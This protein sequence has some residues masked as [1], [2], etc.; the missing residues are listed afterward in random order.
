MIIST[1]PLVDVWAATTK[2]GPRLPAV[3]PGQC[4]SRPASWTVVVAEG[5]RRNEENSFLKIMQSPAR[6]DI[7]KS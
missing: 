4:S 5:V 3:P 1:R 2:N 6:A 7:E